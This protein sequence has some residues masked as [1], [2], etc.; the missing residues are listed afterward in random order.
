MTMVVPMM[1]M[2]RLPTTQ[3]PTQSVHQP[4]TTTPAMMR[5]RSQ[6]PGHT[7]GRSEAASVMRL[8]VVP[9]SSMV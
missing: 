6:Q 8:L 2:R 1:P 5:P 9:M 7:T 4:A 3:E